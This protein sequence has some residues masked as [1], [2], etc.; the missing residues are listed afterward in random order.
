MN[1]ENAIGDDQGGKN[2]EKYNKPPRFWDLWSGVSV[3]FA[4]LGLWQ[5][6][7]NGVFNFFN[8]SPGFQLYPCL[9]ISCAAIWYL[10][11]HV[12]SRLKNV[13]WIFMVAS[14]L[15]CVPFVMTTKQVDRKLEMI[16]KLNAKPH[17]TILLS[18]STFEDDF[19]ELTNTFLFRS[20][21]M[22]LGSDGPKGEILL[23]PDKITGDIIVPV[24][25]LDALPKLYFAL[26]NDSPTPYSSS[27]GLEFA[28]HHGSFVDFS[29]ESEWI[30]TIPSS[31]NPARTIFIPINRNILSSNGMVLPGLE[32]K[33][34][35]S[36]SNNAGNLCSIQL[37]PKDRKDVFLHFWLRF[38]VTTNF[39]KIHIIQSSN[40]VIQYPLRD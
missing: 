4:L 15:C 7:T 30:P 39:S 25:S 14:V 21:D 6:S 29:P 31:Y 23:R 34:C 28:F 35:F 36:V 1:S 12:A 13:P 22:V 19:V 24:K 9:V 32:L 18:N 8:D 5:I 20:S 37:S 10:A 26:R 16:A 27:D 40:N 17:F 2:H 38:P 11:F 33:P 3:G